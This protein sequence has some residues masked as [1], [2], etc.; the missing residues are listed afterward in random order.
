MTDPAKQT[1]WEVGADGRG[2]HEL[3]FNWPGNPMECCGDWTVDGR[4]FVFK[5]GREGISKLWALQEK[6]E[7][8]RRAKN[9]PIRLTSGPGSYYQPVPSRDGKSIFAIGVQPFGELLRYDAER[10]EFVPFLGGRSLVHLSFSRDGKWLAYVSYPEGILWRARSDGSDPLQLTSPPLRVGSPRW[11]ADDT[12]IAFHAIQP[13]RPLKSF[14]ISADGG[15]PE[16]FSPEPISEAC[17]D[18]MPGRN[19]LIFSHSY[20]AEN[21]ALYLFDRQS[22]HSEKIPGTDGLYSP[23]W[24]PD[25]RFLSATDAATDGLLLVD[26]NSSKRTPIAGPV[27]WSTW[28]ADSQYI[29]FVKLGFNWISRVHVPDGREEKVLEVPFRAIWPFKLTPDGSLI[30]LREQGRYDVYSLSLSAQ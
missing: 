23:I 15:V 5:S 12:E 3:R 26:L 25:G 29:Y 27:S 8:W 4:Y 16:P 17:P 21:P 18:W 11:S 19:A 20:G 9:D 7:W 28:S 24:S 14:V 10:K 13:G 22:G 2:L 6:S 1:L 30:L